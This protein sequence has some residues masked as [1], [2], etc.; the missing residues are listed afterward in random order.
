MNA[1]FLNY[2]LSF[3]KIIENF[4]IECDSF[5][6]TAPQDIY[7]FIGN[8]RK[9]G[10]STREEALSIESAVWADTVIVSGSALGVV[11]YTGEETRSAMNSSQARSKVT[12]NSARGVGMGGGDGG[13]EGE[14]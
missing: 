5:C 12:H 2:F 4:R 14:G 13:G 8:F 11:I 3:L 6:G 9:A 7:S 10:D 1:I